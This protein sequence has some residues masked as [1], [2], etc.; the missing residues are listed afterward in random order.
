MVL[1]TII[2]EVASFNPQ[3]LLFQNPQKIAVLKYL[4]KY[5]HF[6]EH[7]GLTLGKRLTF[8]KK[9]CSSGYFFQKNNFWLI[10]SQMKF[11]ILFLTL[12]LKENWKQPEKDN[13]KIA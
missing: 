1:N 6:I 13:K 12:S 2:S 3:S 10:D 5:G 9:N 8:L 7:T 4:A 11:S